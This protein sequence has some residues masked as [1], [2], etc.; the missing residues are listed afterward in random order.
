[1][2]NFTFAVPN[3][4]QVRDI[5]RKNLSALPQETIPGEGSFDC[6]KKMEYTEEVVAVKFYKDNLTSMEI[7]KYAAI[8]NGFDHP[9]T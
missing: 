7:K 9:G 6:F 2:Y 8:I 1:M 4:R 5:E 3:H